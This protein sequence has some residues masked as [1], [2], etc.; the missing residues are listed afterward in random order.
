VLVED[1]LEAAFVV[2]CQKDIVVPQ[3]RI[4]PPD[5]PIEHDGRAGVNFLV[6][7]LGL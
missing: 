6:Q 4:A 7:F 2:I 3:L 1:L 5:A